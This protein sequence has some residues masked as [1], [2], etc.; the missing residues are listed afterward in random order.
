PKFLRDFCFHSNR[1][2]LEDAVRKIT[3]FPAEIL[4]IS[5][6]G[7]FAEGYRADLVLFDP[8]TLRDSGTYEN[9]EQY[10][11][12]IKYVFVNGIAVVDDKG[13]TGA[14]PGKV[15]RKR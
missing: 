1:L 5:D 3:S 14:L 11:E 8:C 9:P 12:G 13:R 15:L 6:R 7:V 4:G 2:S 10:P